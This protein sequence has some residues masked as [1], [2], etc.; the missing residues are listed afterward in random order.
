MNTNVFIFNFILG[1]CVL[2]QY[3]F[4]PFLHT[5]ERL[6]GMLQNN[7]TYKTFNHF[8]F[9]LCAGFGIYLFLYYIPKITQEDFA[10]GGELI[11]KNEKEEEGKEM[12][13]L[14]LSLFYGGALS[15]PMTLGIKTK[16]R[17]VS[18]IPLFIT[19][20]GSL[21]IL[22]YISL[23][24]IA[25]TEVNNIDLE[26]IVAFVASFIIAFQTVIMDALIWSII[27]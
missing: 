26:S 16:N 14:G 15:W 20:L 6:W 21:F 3:S 22:I 9:L 17:W 27:Q 1:A 5:E 10:S 13:W 11:D 25:D 8:M 7:T 2:F 12:L 23:K 18:S 19:A 4:I 24:N